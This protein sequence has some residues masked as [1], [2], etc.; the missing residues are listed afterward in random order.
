MREGGCHCGEV[1]YAVE[2]E[3]IHNSLCHCADCRASAGAPVVGWMAFREKQLTVRSG[4]LTTFEGKTG[5]RRQFCPTCGTGLFFRNAT[6]LPGLVD[7]QSATLDSA[8]DEMPQAHVQCA[9]RLPW[10][11]D[12]SALP[13]FARYPGG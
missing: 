6:F 9:D 12:L 7:I 8:A 3:P 1:R 5:S 13:E 4:A 10:M 11:E 2:G